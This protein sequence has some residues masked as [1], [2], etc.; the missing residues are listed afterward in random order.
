[1]KKYI[2]GLIKFFKSVINLEQPFPKYPFGKFPQASKQEYLDLFNDA[3]NTKYPEI[4][5][6]ERYSNF[7]IDIDWLYNLA[8]HTQI[9]IKQSDINF[10]HGRIL[11]STLRKYLSDSKRKV[12]RF[13][14]LET[15]TARGFSSICMSKA[16]V[17]A[18]AYGSIITIDCIPHNKTIFWNCI[19]DLEGPKTRSELLEKWPIELSNIVFIQGWTNKQLNRMGISRIHFA[20]LDAS[21]T[22]K[23]VI[24]E[25]NY[26]S[27]KQ[28][29]GDII[30][31]DDV[32]PDYFGGVVLAINKIKKEGNYLIKE[33]IASNQRGYAIGVRK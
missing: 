8:L 16:L 32:T 2:K 25:F 9:V 1:M 24:N 19:D 31:F 29:S 21:H 18:N 23:D 12:D 30:V 17:D 13:N 28:L 10:E 3:K 20:F 11:Y 14:I 27:S 22:Y 26:V 7:R 4:D 33:I 15:G 5:E 6:F